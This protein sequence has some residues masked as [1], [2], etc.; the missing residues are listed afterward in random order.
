MAHHQK[1]I[2]DACLA[3]GDALIHG[4]DAKSVYG[5]PLKGTGHLDRA[6]PIGVGFYDGQHLGAGGETAYVRKILR[7]RTQIH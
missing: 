6:M 7:K 4:S 3:E 2:V 1:G 5:Q